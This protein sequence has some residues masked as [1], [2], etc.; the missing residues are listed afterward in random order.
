M[1]R[2]ACVV[3]IVFVLASALRE[4]S[5]DRRR[6]RPQ[7]SDGEQ[8]TLDAF[9]LSRRRGTSEEKKESFSATQDS[10]MRFRHGEEDRFRENNGHLASSGAARRHRKGIME[11]LFGKKNSDLKVP[12][13]C[14]LCTKHVYSDLSLLEISESEKD[15][16]LTRIVR[17]FKDS[18]Y[19]IHPP[20]PDLDSES[21][22][23]AFLEEQMRVSFLGGRAADDG[24]CCPLCIKDVLYHSPDFD[25]EPIESS[26]GLNV[27]IEM[28]Q[29]EGRRADTI[30]STQ[31][32]END[33][34][35]RFLQVSEKF[36]GPS[37]A[38][39]DAAPAGMGAHICC[40]ICPE[41]QSGQKSGGFSGF[42]ELREGAS[43]A[44]A[45]GYGQGGGNNRAE[46]GCCTLCASK[47]Y[48]ASEWGAPPFSEPGNS[49]QNAGAGGLMRPVR[50]DGS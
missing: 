15:R 46:G 24:E 29:P 17:H 18:K 33:G 47:F 45:G 4:G 9:L 10:T 23:M 32:T 2:R 31:Q 12:P 22:T 48:G 42:L 5:A 14:K 20:I 1:V 40:N 39:K 6:G 13:C 25:M 19:A 3:V 44:K 28:D 8:Q 35:V 49:F 21:I 26:A 16:A 37:Q 11:S 7:H 30:V 34:S 41:F 27:F 38:V 43:V 36:M 50:P